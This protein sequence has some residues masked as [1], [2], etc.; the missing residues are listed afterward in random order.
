MTS[1]CKA[2]TQVLLPIILNNFKNNYKTN[3]SNYTNT[4]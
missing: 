4:K 1:F 2:K 3:Y